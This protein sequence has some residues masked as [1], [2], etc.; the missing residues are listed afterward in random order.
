MR[1]A[2]EVLVFYR[3]EKGGG[4]ADKVL[5]MLKGGGGGM[6]SFHLYR[7]VGIRGGGS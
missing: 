2:R 4:G 5:A 6:K 1:G 7:P 3:Y